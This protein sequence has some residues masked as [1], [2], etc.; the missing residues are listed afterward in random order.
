MGVY[1]LDWEEHQLTL[2]PG[3]CREV[4]AWRTR[5][6]GRSAPPRVLLRSE[7]SRGGSDAS[8]SSVRPSLSFSS[9]GTVLTFPLLSDQRWPNDGVSSEFFEIFVPFGCIWSF[10]YVY[11]F[12]FSGLLAAF[13]S[14]YVP[15]FSVSHEN[16]WKISTCEV[17]YSQ[18]F[19]VDDQKKSRMVH[20][21]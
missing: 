10:D 3:S 8:W 17:F 20:F 4:R 15:K 1:G 13:S 16:V 11:W 19:S 21:S 12:F 14:L 6:R 5:G 18:F 2:E 9:P 7:P